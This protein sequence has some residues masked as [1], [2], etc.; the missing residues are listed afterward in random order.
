VKI[1]P[2]QNTAIVPV[3][4]R[5]TSLVGPQQKTAL[6]AQNDTN[7]SKTSGNHEPRRSHRAIPLEKGHLVDIYV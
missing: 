2:N 3:A 5:R 6:A 4:N 1:N 7:P